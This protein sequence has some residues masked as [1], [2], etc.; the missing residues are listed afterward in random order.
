MRRQTNAAMD[1]D[2]TISVTKSVRPA[3]AATSGKVVMPG[4]FIV[5]AARTSIAEKDKYFGGAAAALAAVACGSG[6]VVG[7]VIFDMA[8]E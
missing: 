7:S 3:S 2:R 4:P 1:T 8:L 6:F 5:F